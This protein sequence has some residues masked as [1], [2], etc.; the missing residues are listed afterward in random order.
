MNDDERRLRAEQITVLAEMFVGLGHEAP[1]ERVEYY[2]R[3]LHRVPP[4]ILRMACDKAVLDERGG[5]VPGPGQIMQAAEEIESKRRKHEFKQ[6]AAQ[7]WADHLKLVGS[8]GD[9]AA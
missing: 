7:Q 6:R 9:G 2:L 4:R 1:D 8:S 3:L 5:F